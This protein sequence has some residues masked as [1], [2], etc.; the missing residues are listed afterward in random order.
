[1]RYETGRTLH[2]ALHL[3]DRQIL[4]HN[5]KDMMGKVDDLELELSGQPPTVTALLV[6]PQAWG[7]RIPGLLGRVVVSVH[8]R[9]HPREEPG[10]VR[11]PAA[12]ITEI[13]SAVEIAF[14]PDRAVSDWVDKHLIARLPGA[15]HAP[16]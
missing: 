8:R 12:H 4:V 14:P 6:G 11:I 15:D 13:H 7:R 1:M 5:N 3:L 9:L 16:E 10:P 2:A